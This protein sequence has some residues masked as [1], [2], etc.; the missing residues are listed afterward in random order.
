MHY[1]VIALLLIV[2]DNYLPN[3]KKSSGGGGGAMAEFIM[4]EY[5]SNIVGVPQH[6]YGTVENGG[7]GG[8]GDQ[9][10]NTINSGKF[11]FL[12]LIFI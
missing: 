10:P 4:D 6:S 12:L 5:E 1:F 7:G 8:G 11:V 9:Q 2:G 3:V